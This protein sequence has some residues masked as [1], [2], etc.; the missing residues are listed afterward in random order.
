MDRG[1]YIV[2]ERSLDLNRRHSTVTIV[3]MFKKT[4]GK[5]RKR[6]GGETTTLWQMIKCVLRQSSKSVKGRSCLLGVVA[7]QKS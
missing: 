7:L 3:Y 6:R 1:G 5:C 4:A 2:A